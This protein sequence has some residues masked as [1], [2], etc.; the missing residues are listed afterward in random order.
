MTKP[1]RKILSAALSAS[2]LATAVSPAPAAA[3]SQP[4]RGACVRFS[5]LPPGHSFAYQFP[6]QGTW[7]AADPAQQAVVLY[8]GADQAVQARIWKQS[9]GSGA[10]FGADNMRTY[11]LTLAPTS[12][13]TSCAAGASSYCVQQGADGW[14]M[15][16]DD[17][18]SSTSNSSASTA[19]PRKDDTAENVAKLIGGAVVIA[20]L[21][22]LFSSSSSSSSRSSDANRDAESQT[23]AIE[24]ANRE[25]AREARESAE[26][27]RRAAEWS[28]RMRNPN[29]LGW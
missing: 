3:Q 2:L 12:S 21:A 28:E 15:V 13:T 26:R 18:G 14:V 29:P 7:V 24:R 17:A 10:G 5:D 4:V 8:S 20:L 27:D 19:P 16:R 23:N 22:S 1:F 25:R 9:P 11:T 6:S